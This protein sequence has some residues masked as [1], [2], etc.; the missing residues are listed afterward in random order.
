MRFPGSIS[1]TGSKVLFFFQ[2]GGGG[3]A[4]VSI[5][6]NTKKLTVTPTGGTTQTMT[7]ALAADTTYNVW[8]RFQKGNGTNAF[9]SIGVSTTTTRPT[10]TVDSNNYV[11]STNGTTTFDS[12]HLQISGT[13]TSGTNGIDVV[14]DYLRIAD[15]SVN[16]IGNNPN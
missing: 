7:N 12:N 10:A 2:Q 14:V 4:S 3:R 15:C 13:Q 16:V 9:I 5:A 8:V 1:N 6:G 11:E